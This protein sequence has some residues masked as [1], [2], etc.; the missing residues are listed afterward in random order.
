MIRYA[1]GVTNATDTVEVTSPVDVFVRIHRCNVHSLFEIVD[2]HRV[3]TET[4]DLD[5]IFAP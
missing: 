5:R 4:F 2:M 1:S 3:S